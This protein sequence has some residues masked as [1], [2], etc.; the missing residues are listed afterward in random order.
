MKFIVTT[1]QQV[2]QEL[3]VSKKRLELR[4]SV[5]DS[6]DRNKE[7]HRLVFKLDETV[8]LIKRLCSVVFRVNHDGEDSHDLRGVQSSVK[9]IDEELSTET[10]SLSRFVDGEA[11][12]AHYW[13]WIFG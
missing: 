9:G 11:S 13:N 10:R 2:F 7:N 3:S 12:D 1:V 5:A 4:E 8:F 6:L